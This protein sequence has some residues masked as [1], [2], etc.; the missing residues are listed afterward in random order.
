MTKTKPIIK[1]YDLGNEQYQIKRRMGITPKKVYTL[2][3]DISD[4]YF[5]N[6]ND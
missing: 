6:K 5:D 4:I 1:I 2:M 3:R